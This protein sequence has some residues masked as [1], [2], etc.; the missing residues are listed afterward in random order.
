VEAIVS[1]GIIYSNIEISLVVDPNGAK[2]RMEI[3]D[4]DAKKEGFQ[5]EFKKDGTTLIQR[6][7]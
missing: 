3:L 7:M 5:F 6:K 1:C 2:D 4:G